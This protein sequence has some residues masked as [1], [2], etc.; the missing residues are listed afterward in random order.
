MRTARS[1]F[2]TPPPPSTCAG[3]QLLSNSSSDASLQ[4]YV[5]GRLNNALQTA[6]SLSSADLT[7][8]AV[9]NLVSVLLVLVA[10]NN[11]L[12]NN[13]LDTINTLVETLASR[14]TSSS[15]QS[16]VQV[17]AAIIQRR[18]LVRGGRATEHDDPLPARPHAAPAR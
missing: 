5:Q 1:P 13:L 12:S 18:G 14:A 15:A 4:T 6:Y 16:F 9:N 17:L 7:P 2:S 8:D 11:V 10:A 3:T